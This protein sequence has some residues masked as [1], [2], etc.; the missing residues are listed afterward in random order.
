MSRKKNDPHDDYYIRGII[1]H[2]VGLMFENETPRIDF[3]AQGVSEALRRMTKQ[4]ILDKFYQYYNVEGILDKVHT[5]LN[6]GSVQVAHFDTEQDLTLPILNLYLQEAWDED[7]NGFNPDLVVLS[8]QGTP[9]GFTPEAA[10]RLL[11]KMGFLVHAPY[12]H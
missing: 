12:R 11:L 7:H 9:I 10:K 5:M 3:H 2:D 6:N 1:G 4:E 8:A